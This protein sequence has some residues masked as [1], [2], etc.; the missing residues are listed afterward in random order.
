[1]EFEQFARTNWLPEEQALA[2]IAS[3]MADGP[4]DLHVYPW[5]E[6]DEAQPAG[7]RCVVPVGLL[8][9]TSRGR[10]RLRS[11]DPGERAEVNHAYLAE[12]ADV[13]A[14]A[15]GVRRALQV[16]RQP[17]VARDLGSPRRVPADPR[18]GVL[19]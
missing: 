3:P 15:H 11:A 17:A 18:H 8:T 5:V 12:A 4:F 14:L 2:K 10:L 1:E 7:W 16:G 19:A 6:P 9:P 13:A